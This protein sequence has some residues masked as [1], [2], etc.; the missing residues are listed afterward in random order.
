V[1]RLVLDRNPDNFFAETEQA[2][3][4]PSHLVPGFDFSNDPLLQGRL[5]SYLDT[6][7]SRLGGPN[8]HQLPINAPRCPFHN[9]QRDAMAQMQ[10]PPGRAAY[11]PNSLD[12]A[13]P[14]ES[15]RH[16]FHSVAEANPEPKARLR[17]ESFA[18]HYSQARLFYRSLTPPEQSHLAAA[19]AFEQGKVET[20]AIRARVLGH[21]AVID[22]ALLAEVCARLGV[23]AATVEPASPA[24]PPQ[25]LPPALSLS[26]LASRQGDLRGRELAVLVA[27]GVDGALLARLRKAVTDAGAHL[28]VVAPKAGGVSD[29]QGAAVA[30]DHALA[31][32]PSCLFDAVALL[33]SEPGMAHDDGAA[34]LLKAA[35][36]GSD[37]AVVK[38]ADAASL[39]RFIAVAAEG[40]HFAREGAPGTDG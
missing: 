5:F 17:P 2:A 10:R 37:A 34:E 9:H 22:E 8:F 29:A 24:V 25:D 3:F 15:P 12:P 11:E 18:D 30:A 7:L 21:L 33:G 13:G 40:K 6:Q 27:D 16:G 35:G 14:R 4:C 39:Q 1:G 32:A 31:G 20:E 36:I 26:Q 23:D 38:I 19:I 28:A